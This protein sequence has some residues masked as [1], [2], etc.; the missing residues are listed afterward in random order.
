MDKCF[1]CAKTLTAFPS[2]MVNMCSKCAPKNNNLPHC[3]FGELF[4]NS[5]TDISFLS[6]S[7]SPHLF[8]AISLNFWQCATQTFQANSTPDHYYPHIL[9]TVYLY[10]SVCLFHSVAFSFPI[11]ISILDTWAHFSA[12]SHPPDSVGMCVFL[13]FWLFCYTHLYI[14][15]T[16]RCERA[17]FAG[18]CCLISE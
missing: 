6:I 10:E 15:I 13:L 14:Y 4:N 9:S 11:P 17:K 12:V 2:K 16:H 7:F 18:N 8:L 5:I 1:Q 3:S